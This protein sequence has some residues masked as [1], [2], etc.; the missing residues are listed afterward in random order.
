MSRRR[1]LVFIAAVTVLGAAAPATSQKRDGGEIGQKQHDL[2]RTQKRLSEERQ[3]AAEAKKREASVLADLEAID[4]RLTDKRRQVAALDERIKKAQADIADLRSDIADLAREQS[5]QER[6]L[7]RRLRA[8]YK[9]EAQGG[10]L[11][12]ILSGDDPVARAVQLRHLGTLASVDARLIRE[13]RVTSEGLV[14]RHAQLERR[15][16]ELTVLRAEAEEERAEAGREIVK[17]R[18]LLARVKDERAYHDRMVG[19]LSEAAGRLEAL[20]RDLQEKQ[21]RVA[22]APPPNRPRTAPQFD[23]APGTG[24][25]A[26]R[27]RLAW[28]AEGRIVGEYGAQVHPRFGTKIFR[29]GIDIDVAEGTSIGAVAAGQVLYTG[30][31]RGYGNLIIVD[32][33]GEYYTLYAHVADIRVAEGDEVKAGQV[34]GT[35]GDTGSLSGPRLYF[36]VRHSGKPQDPS[37]WLR[38][39]G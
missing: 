21:R 1:A 18:V 16:K 25:A 19:E 36:E 34:I 9:I 31:F 28:P 17:R 7:E 14:E 15:Q 12:L 24:F 11:P 13:Y 26:L 20:I 30:W 35:V 5:G 39:R 27:G 22:K 29:N 4:R 23:V 6:V 3:K 8:L 33:G 32:H 10:A 2:Q 38:P 37:Q